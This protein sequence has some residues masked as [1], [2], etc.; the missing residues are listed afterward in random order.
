MSFCCMPVVFT[1][2][3][4]IKPRQQALEPTCAASCALRVQGRRRQEGLVAKLLRDQLDDATYQKVVDAVDAAKTS[5]ATWVDPDVAAQVTLWREGLIAGDQS[6][7]EAVLSVCARAK[8]AARNGKG[9]VG[10]S[11]GE[12]SEEDSGDG[13][14]ESS[15][16]GI[17]GGD[18]NEDEEGPASDSQTQ[19]A[20]AVPDAQQ[21]RSLARQLQQLVAEEQEEKQAAA[22]AASAAAEAQG[23]EVPLVKQKRQQAPAAAARAKK[24][25]NGMRSLEAALKVAAQAALSMQ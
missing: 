10:S 12:L 3:L 16:S 22:S 18:G 21:I 20:V 5:S 4:K 19:G 23:I 1:V 9:A 24:I 7:L 17:D 8:A 14:A 13:M 6:V 11:S 2:S 25:R 15:V